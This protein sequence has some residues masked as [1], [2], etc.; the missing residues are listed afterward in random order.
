MRTARAQQR[1]QS[2]AEGDVRIGVKGEVRHGELEAAIRLH[3]QNLGKLLGEARLS[4]R[5]Q[6]HH[7][8]LAF[9][10]L[11][12]EIGGEG[13]VEQA[14]GMRVF[15]RPEAGQRSPVSLPDRRRYVLADP[16]DRQD[17]CA[18]VGAG[19]EGARRVTAVVGRGRHLAAGHADRGGDVVQHP[20]LGAELGPHGRRK[21]PPG[22]WKGPQRRDHHPL[23]P[24]EGIL[25]EDDA[26]QIVGGDPRLREAGQSRLARQARIVLAAGEPFLLHRRHDFAIHDQGGGGVMVVAGNAEDGA[27]ARATRLPP[28]GALRPGSGAERGPASPP[29]DA[30]TIQPVRF[31]LSRTPIA[32]NR[33]TIE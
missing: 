17:G 1:L 21:L 23:E 27:H 6:A 22:A 15:D 31:G 7:L 25:V 29:S 16:V 10:D 14:K 33:P 4:K 12:T 28:P 9:V 19:E 30:G 20:D 11:E 2:W 24:H 18:V 3:L 8:V 13:G 26:V 5:R 32:V